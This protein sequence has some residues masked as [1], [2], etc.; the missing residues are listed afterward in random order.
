LRPGALIMDDSYPPAFSV[1]A[2]ARRLE[3]DADILFSNAGM[4]RL[5]QPIRETILVPPSATEVLAS[6]GVAAFREEVVRDANELTACVL[7]SLLTGRP[8]G[9]FPPTLGLAEISDLV[10]HYR[11]LDALDI[12]PARLQCDSYFLSE[13]AVARFRGRFGQVYESADRP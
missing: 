9:A 4:L 8:D 6:F 13:E 2:A 3:S 12:G 7:S 5:P 11:E 1:A 10:A